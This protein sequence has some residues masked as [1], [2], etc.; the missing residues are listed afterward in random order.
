M[1]VYALLCTALWH[2]WGWEC[3]PLLQGSLLPFADGPCC[4]VCVVAGGVLVRPWISVNVRSWHLNSAASVRHSPPWRAADRTQ[5]AAVA[6]HPPSAHSSHSHAAAAAA[7]ATA[8]R[9]RRRRR[10]CCCCCSRLTQPMTVVT[11]GITLSTII[12]PPLAAGLMSIN[13][14]GLKGWQVRLQHSF[15]PWQVGNAALNDVHMAPA[16][17]SCQLTECSCAL[18]PSAWMA[19]PLDAQLCC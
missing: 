6:S 8:C 4:D 5:E 17:C 16:S 18:R 15:R 19:H 10:R 1:S 7:I 14:A 12:A 2:D 13:A 3:L 11:L 9:R